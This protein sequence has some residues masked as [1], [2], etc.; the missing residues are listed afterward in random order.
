MVKKVV[1]KGKLLRLKQSIKRIVNFLSRR[2]IW[3]GLLV[4]FV[5]SFPAP[6][7]IAAFLEFFQNLP[8][9]AIWIIFFP[10]WLSN[11]LTQWMVN[12]ELVDPPFWSLILWA[13]SIFA[14]MFLGVV[15][16]YGI[17]R[18]R[19]WRRTPRKKHNLKTSHV[20][21]L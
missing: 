17:H 14:G 3:S 13:V 1:K 15:F 2:Y 20:T 7:L 21:A 11:L 12:L 18:I 5:W 9:E 8:E 16:T 4:G 19:V 10:L 6:F